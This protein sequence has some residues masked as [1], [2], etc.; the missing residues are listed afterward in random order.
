MR[1]KLGREDANEYRCCFCC[2]V[3]TG[4]MFLGLW[5][6]VA[7]LVVLSLFTIMMIHP[8]LLQFPNKTADAV[9]ADTMNVYL[10]GYDDRSE[11]ATFNWFQDR[12][13]T[14]EDKFVGFLITFCSFMI[15]V[16][17][18][19]GTLRGRP[20]YLMPFFC[21]QVFDFCITCLSVVC[22]FSYMP[23]IKEWI[24]DQDN[25]PFKERLV[26]YDE[27][28]LMLVVV[29]VFVLIMSLKAYFIG[30]VW[31]CYKYLSKR[32]LN[33]AVSHFME[34]GPDSEMLL[35][36]KYEDAIKYPPLQNMPPPPAYT[37]ASN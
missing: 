25:L 35:P 2:H 8:Q 11:D 18:V 23:N 7:H 10:S 3:R 17:L 34:D 20:G 22:Y 21:L 16:M 29:T 36:P 33:E 30:V 1:M 12:K 24:T 4:T 27:Q 13:W 5:H 31:A 19:Y 6:L 32:L 37:P 26:D 9:A 14:K 28:W 15:T